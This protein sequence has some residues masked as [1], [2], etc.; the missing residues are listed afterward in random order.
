MAALEQVR[1]ESKLTKPRRKERAAE[2][3]AEGF[4]EFVDNGRV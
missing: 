4:M 3:I 2:L 1:L